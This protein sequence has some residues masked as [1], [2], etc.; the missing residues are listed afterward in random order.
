MTPLDTCKTPPYD[1]PIPYPNIAMLAMSDPATLAATVTSEGFPVATV[2]TEILL[3]SGDEAGASG[4][5]I[6]GGIMGS[7]KFKLGSMSVKCEGQQAAY[8]GSLVGQNNDSNSN[9]P[10]GT[11][12]DPSSTNVFV[13]P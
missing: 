8:Q 2:A 1:I 11:Q 6:S 5:I 7:A 10:A 13:G 12:T 9:M 4:G 3:S